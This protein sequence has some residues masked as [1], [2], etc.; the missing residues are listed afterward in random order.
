[1]ET[2]KNN[3]KNTFVIL[4][5]LCGIAVNIFAGTTGKISGKITDSETG[6]PLPGANIIIDGTSIGTASNID[7]NYSILNISPGSYTLK[8][9]MVGFSDVFVKEVHVEI[10]LTTNVDVQLTTT[11][12][13]SAEVII[14][15]ERPVVA[16]DVSNSQMNITGKSIESLPVTTVEQVI[17]LQAGVQQN[18]SG[19]IVRGGSANQTVFMVDGF[20]QNDERANLP[21]TTVSLSSVKEIKVQTGGFNAEYGNLRSGL[22]NVVTKEGSKTKYS[23]T[24]NFRMAPA[25]PKHFGNSIYDPYS[26]FNRPYNDPN[27]MWEGTNSGAWDSYMQRQYPQFEG[28]NSISESTL[29]NADEATHLTPAAAKQIYDWEHRRVGDIEKPDY[30]VDVGFGGPVPFVSSMLG[31]LRFYFSYFNTNE[32]FVFPLS[33]DA[34]KED[35]GQIKFI[36]NITTNLKLTVNGMYGEINSV[37]SYNWNPPTGSVLRSTAGVANLVN[38][39]NLYMPGYYSPSDIYRTSVGA[40]LTHVFS[41]ETF[42]EIKLQHKINRYNTFELP[43]RDTS[44]IFEV[45]PDY[46][47]DEAPYGYWGESVSGIDGMSLGGWMNLG[48]DKSV[49][50]TTSLKFDYTSQVNQSNMVKA[51]FEIVY[52]NYDINTGTFSPS[53]TTWTRSQI[54]ELTPFRLSAYV[55][56]KLEYEGFVMNVG[57]RADYSAPNSNWYQLTEYD[58]YLQAGYGTSI[59]ED[60]PT[61][62]IAAQLYLSPRLG[63]SHPITTNSKL[64][65]N[66][67]HFKSEPSSSYRFLLQRESNGM[68]KFI[69]NPNMEPEKTIA[70]ELGFSQNISDMFLL[71]IAAYYKDI[72]NQPGWIFYQNT[73]SSV[74]Y[75]TSAN[76][77]YQDIRG[78][79]VTLSKTRGNWFRGFINYTYDVRTSGYFGLTRYYEDPIKQRDYLTLNPYQS[80]PQPQPYARLNVEFLTPVNYGAEF[81]GFHPLGSWSFNVLA[82]WRSGAYDTF[83][84]NSL[85][86]IIDNVQWVDWFNID[87][88]FSKTIVMESFNLQLYF[89]VANVL[90]L[91][92][93][94]SAGFS[95]RFDRLDYMES[96]H[97][98]WEEGAEKGNDKVGD[99]RAPGVEYVNI[100]SV[101]NINQV[102]Q[103]NSKTLYYDSATER[104]FQYSNNAWQRADQSYVQSV[105][106]NKAYIDNPNIQ[107]FTFLNPRT[108]TL[109]IRIDF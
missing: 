56:D 67:G 13:S 52:N 59:E 91:K 37:S 61:E 5:I 9:S 54:Y 10:D 17:A 82:D 20:S 97:F 94:S 41:A 6:M 107:A 30:N 55:Q 1:M 42:Y 27:V 68:V 24:L 31:D 14:V 79:E 104:Y 28:W 73:N 77:N 58:Q 7:G 109:G 75:R 89:D 46:F 50:S 96:L 57:L 86:G 92:R 22:I 35:Y 102:V 105:I 16:R 48:R 103:P 106:A 23:A 25:A 4:S 29:R 84:P 108:F 70:Y 78:F 32:M 72:T 63:I 8:F 69:G 65:F 74:S 49:N 85:P 40:K 71:N 66:Y 3:I 39:E 33:R 2:K 47:V 95:D 100:K 93:L 62:K 53:M 87:I 38:R 36:S 19:I 83:N 34:Y 45:V 80:K 44:K 101:T 90:N 15:A 76:N 99:Y 64:Y 81:G 60:V 18:S 21:Y 26:Y 43:G 11:S 12:I 51:G 88:R 98:D